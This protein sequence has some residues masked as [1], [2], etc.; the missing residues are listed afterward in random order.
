MAGPRG[1]LSQN[2]LNWGCRWR[3]QGLNLNPA[4]A[5]VLNH[6][7][8]AVAHISLEALYQ[9]EIEVA[10]AVELSMNHKNP[11]EMFPASFGNEPDSHPDV[12][13]SKIV[14][15]LNANNILDDSDYLAGTIPSTACGFAG[16]L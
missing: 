12:L 13:H 14:H 6:S 9:E 2:G 7:K 1:G 3:R 16:H 4:V 11:N 10:T 15:S 5:G 8:L